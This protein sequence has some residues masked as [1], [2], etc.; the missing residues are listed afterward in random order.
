MNQKNTSK[1]DPAFVFDLDGVITWPHTTTIDMVALGYVY[2]LLEQGAYVATNTGRSYEWVEKNVLSAL[3]K[4]AERSAKGDIFDKLFVVCEKG[5][6]CIKR[7][8]GRFAP[9]PSRFALSKEANEITRHVYDENRAQFSSM[10]WDSTK[11]TMASLEKYPTADITQFTQEKELVASKLQAALAGREAKID[12]TVAAIDVEHPM[13]GKH[14]GAELIFEWIASH[15][16]TAHNNFVC[17]GDSR[18]DYEMARY[19]AQQGAHITFVFVGDKG[20]T[21]KEDPDV[22][23]VRTKASF[24]DGTREYFRNASTI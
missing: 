20:I 3:E 1:H 8:N 19:F 11:R 12:P 5:G 4:M 6:E 21:F 9:Q 22:A 13:A 10:F 2:E 7:V 23:L 17:F 15:K 16:G 24:A 14:A 18:S